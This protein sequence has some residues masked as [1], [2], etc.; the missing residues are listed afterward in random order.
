MLS[1]IFKVIRTFPTINKGVFTNKASYHSKNKEDI[2]TNLENL[3]YNNPNDVIKAIKLFPKNYSEISSSE[4]FKWIYKN[5]KQRNENLWGKFQYTKSFTTDKNVS[6][7]CKIVMDANDS[8]VEYS[9]LNAKEALEEL[10]KGRD[11]F[12]TDH[13][14]KSFIKVLSSYSVEDPYTQK[15]KFI[16]KELYELFHDDKSLN[17]NHK[18]Q[19]I[20]SALTKLSPKDSYIFTSTHNIFSYTNREKTEEKKCEN[21]LVKNK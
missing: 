3:D 20:I 4:A 19:E 7:I 2:H 6:A 9:D 11:I 17:S 8:S 18:K 13:T 15:I 12:L 21:G 1:Q 14:N 5:A 10:Q 16:L